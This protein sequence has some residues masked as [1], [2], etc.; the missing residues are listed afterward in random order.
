MPL[1][2]SISEYYQALD[3]QPDF[4]PSQMSIGVIA[5]KAEPLDLLCAYFWQPQVIGSA[6]DAERFALAV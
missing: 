4:W 3:V 6:S 2:R 5:A 1:N